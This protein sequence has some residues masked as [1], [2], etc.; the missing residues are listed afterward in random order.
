MSISSVVMIYIAGFLVT[1]VFILAHYGNQEVSFWDAFT[2]SYDKTRLSRYGEMVEPEWPA[3]YVI[4]WPIGLLLP[5]IY[6][7]ERLCVTAYELACHVQ[8]RCGGTMLG[9]LINRWLNAMVRFVRTHLYS[10]T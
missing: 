4:I 7:C 5:A 9:R 1:N 6:I 10:R 3:L 2:D 8:L